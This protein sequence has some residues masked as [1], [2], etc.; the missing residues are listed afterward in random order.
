MEIVHNIR[1]N[2]SAQDL[3]ANRSGWMTNILTNC[4]TSCVVDVTDHS[5]GVW[6]PLALIS[7]A[8]NCSTIDT[9]YQNKTTG[10]YRQFSSAPPSPWSITPFKRSVL[11]VQV[12]AVAGRQVRV[13][14][15]VSYRS[16]GGTARTI[17]TSQDFY[18][19]FPRL[20]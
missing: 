4:S 6:G 9:I 13:T 8:G 7:C 17:S 12:G 20:N 15:S 5:V 11:V 14:S 18:N 3:D 19:W 1:D 16:Y 2:N 10:L